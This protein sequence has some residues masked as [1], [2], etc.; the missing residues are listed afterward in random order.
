MGLLAGACLVS[1]RVPL[2][3]GRAQIQMGMLRMLVP[4]LL[5]LAP[6]GG[7]KIDFGAHIGGAVVGTLAGALLLL[8]WKRGAS[9]PPLRRVGQGVAGIGGILFVLSFALVGTHFQ[10]NA[11]AYTSVTLLVP[12]AEAPAT[13]EA[14][15]ER[16]PDLVA[17]YPHD[18]RAHLF[19]A[20]R[21]EDQHDEVG[22]E[23]E[24]RAALGEPDILRVH[25]P[26]RRLESTIRAALARLLLSTDRAG[27]ARDVVR[28]VC[29]AGEAGAPPEVV[30]SLG[31]CGPE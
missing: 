21:D 20:F 18:P 9:H 5:P 28:P 10:E 7:E 22:A 11:F 30:K 14:W 8:T 27:E 31:L 25:F 24:L 13:G 15:A 16:A 12:D 17:K 19:M 29:N 26:N 3:A 6:V 23:R 1:Y 2:G 4:S